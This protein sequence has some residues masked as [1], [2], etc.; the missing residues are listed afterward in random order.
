MHRSRLQCVY[1]LVHRFHVPQVILNRLSWQRVWTIPPLESAV[2]SLAW[3]PDG[4]GVQGLLM[5]LGLFVCLFVC[6]PLVPCA[7]LDSASYTVDHN[8]NIITQYMYEQCGL[9]LVLG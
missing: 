2:G 1:D 8:M 4:R 7:L 3:R 6:C 5:Y 9:V